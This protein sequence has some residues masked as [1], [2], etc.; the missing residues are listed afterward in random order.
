MLSTERTEAPFLDG[1]E[2]W[3]NAE[4]NDPKGR[5]DKDDDLLDTTYKSERQIISFKG[6]GAGSTRASRVTLS[7][8]ALLV[9]WSYL[10]VFDLY[11]R[12]HWETDKLQGAYAHAPLILMVLIYFAWRQ[13]EVFNTPPTQQI[14]FK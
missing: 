5:M 10:P 6:G 2:S 11:A 14:S 9:V 3:N 8:L 7:L 4:Q 13:R 12:Q 1:I